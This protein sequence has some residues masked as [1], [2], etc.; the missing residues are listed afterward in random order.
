MLLANLRRDLIQV[1]PATL[2]GTASSFDLSSYLFF[3]SSSL[4]PLII[5]VWVL[6]AST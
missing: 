5:I 2:Q 1:H 6:A 4:L 3:F